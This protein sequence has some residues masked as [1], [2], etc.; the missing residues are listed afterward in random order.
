MNDS[1]PYFPL[2]DLQDSQFGSGSVMMAPRF[3]QTGHDEAVSTL[4]P[5]CFLP[6]TADRLRRLVFRRRSN[7]RDPLGNAFGSRRFTGSIFTV[8]VRHRKVLGAG[9]AKRRARPDRTRNRRLGFSEPTRRFMDDYVL[10]RLFDRPGIRRCPLQTFRCPDRTKK[11]DG[12]KRRDLVPVH[13]L[14]RGSDHSV[15]TSNLRGSNLSGCRSHGVHRL[16]TD[17]RNPG[18]RRRTLHDLPDRRRRLLGSV[19]PGRSSCRHQ[20]HS[21]QLALDL[22]DRSLSD[23]L[24]PINLA[25]RS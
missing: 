10:W 8:V 13:G 1:K 14:E 12:L 24:D 3:L 11:S 22:G 7:I 6:R 2:S 17:H 20:N 4:P 18:P 19:L 16:Q 5:A 9:A 23:R 15:A 25:L 21:R